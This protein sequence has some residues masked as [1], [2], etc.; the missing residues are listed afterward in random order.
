[1]HRIKLN[2]FICREKL[3]E[4]HDELQKKEAALAELQPDVSQNRKSGFFCQ[5]FPL[6][7]SMLFLLKLF[8]Q[9]LDYEILVW[10]RLS[11]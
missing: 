5:F 11:S 9:S 10:I 6:C 8:A 3:S 2:S 1:M 7:G 4:V